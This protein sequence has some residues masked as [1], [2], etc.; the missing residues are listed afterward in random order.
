MEVTD[1]WNLLPHRYPFLLV[2]RVLEF[3]ADKRIV[4]IKNVTINEPQFTGHF[5]NSPVFPGVMIVEA[6]AQVSGILAFKSRNRTL[7]DGYIYYLA[8]TDKTKF[9]HSVVPGDQL[10]LEVEIV[11]LRNHWLKASGKAYVG[12]KLACSTLLTCAEQKVS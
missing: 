5:P 6:L 1:I 11:N 3:E 7:D 12:D 10:R 2:D 9:K 4:A 8:G